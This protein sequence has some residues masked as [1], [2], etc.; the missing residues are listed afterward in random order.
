MKPCAYTR[1]TLVTYLCVFQRLHQELTGRRSEIERLNAAASESS[2]AL[3]PAS[4]TAARDSQ[5]KS[6]SGGGRTRSCT[7]PGTG[8]HSRTPPV[9]ISARSRTPPASVARSKTPPVCSTAVRVLPSVR[10]QTPP[11]STSQSRTPAS[12][13]RRSVT[14]PGSAAGNKTAK[15][16]VPSGSPKRQQVPSASSAQGSVKEPIARRAN[17]ALWERYRLLLELSASRK[18]QLTDALDRQREVRNV[19]CWLSAVAVLH[20]LGFAHVQFDNSLI[21]FLYYSCC[22]EVLKLHYKLHFYTLLFVFAQINYLF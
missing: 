4:A 13:Q 9:T 19:S 22:F 7:P 11:V 15:S 14:P 17:T 1:A 18:K 5:N 8:L 10:S 6:T 16:R 3:E 2:D 12:Q 20:A 21:F